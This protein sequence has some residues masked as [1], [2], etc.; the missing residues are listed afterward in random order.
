MDP[1]AG[2]PGA[3]YSN[4]DDSEDGCRQLDPE[5]L[6]GYAWRLVQDYDVGHFYKDRRG[7]AMNE[8]D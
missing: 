6:D 4:G 5:H 7:E 8:E 1:A 2:R 3:V